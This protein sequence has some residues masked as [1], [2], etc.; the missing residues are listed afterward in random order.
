ML[1]SRVAIPSASSASA[2]W[3]QMWTSVPL[4]IRISC[5]GSGSLNELRRTYAPR[6]IASAG[7][8]AGF[9]VG[10]ALA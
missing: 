2:A 6:S 9:Q 10:N 3:A 1:T 7:I 4:A 5:G 8:A